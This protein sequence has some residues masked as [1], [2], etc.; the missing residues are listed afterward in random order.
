MSGPFNHNPDDPQPV[1]QQPESAQPAEPSRA[2]RG[3]ANA[4]D[5]TALEQALQE[6]LTLASSGAPIDPAEMDALRRAAKRHHSSEVNLDIAADL[7]QAVLVTHFRSLAAGDSFWQTISR[8]I[9]RRLCDDPHTEARLD[10]L[11]KRLREGE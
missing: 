6:T 11:W 10:R 3:D 5:R 8:D 4:I 2:P 1:F 9:A 7:I